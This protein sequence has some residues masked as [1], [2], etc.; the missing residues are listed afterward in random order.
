MAQQDIK[1]LNYSDSKVLEYQAS[2]KVN[3][4]EVLNLRKN[5]PGYN[6][7]ET[8]KIENVVDDAAVPKLNEPVADMEAKPIFNG[9]SKTSYGKS[10]GSSAFQGGNYSSLRDLMTPEEIARYDEHWLDVAEQISNEALENQIQFIKNG[11]ITR[12]NGKIYEPSKVCCR[13]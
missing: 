10:S 8:N 11:G 6:I 9:G 5:E 2:K 13:V 12:Q 7:I 3:Y 1:N 4:S